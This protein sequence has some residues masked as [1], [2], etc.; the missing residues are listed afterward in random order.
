MCTD[1]YRYQE[2]GDQNWMLLNG[3][4]IGYN[5]TVETT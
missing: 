2:N 5:F 3:Y 1:K 4:K